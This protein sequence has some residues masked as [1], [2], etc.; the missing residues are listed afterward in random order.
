MIQS[1]MELFGISKKPAPTIE[2]SVSD[3]NIIKGTLVT[4]S[5]TMHH[6]T[7]AF[8]STQ[9]EL[10]L[11][12]SLTISPATTTSYS[13]TAVGPGG[14]SEESFTIEVNDPLI[15]K[16]ALLDREKAAAT[17]RH[18]PWVA[19]VS[20]DIDPTDI[21]LGSAELD[22]NDVFVA[23][24]KRANYPGDTDADIVDSWFTELCGSVY[25]DTVNDELSD[26]EKRKELSQTVILNDKYRMYE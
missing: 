1:L 4:I 26:P 21:S 22:W 15:D 3:S 9:G 5:W 2:L 12:G 14:S 16:R 23:K 13:I 8:L 7:K 18:E 24:L 11:S 19:I 6:A 20:L 25:M 17:A 10:P